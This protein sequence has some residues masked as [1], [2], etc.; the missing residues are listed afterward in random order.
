MYAGQN[1]L[2]IP[3]LSFSAYWNFLL[4]VCKAQVPIK[5]SS[6]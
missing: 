6:F 5:M 2:D 4:T 3:G 1:P